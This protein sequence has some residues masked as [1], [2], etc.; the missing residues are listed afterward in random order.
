MQPFFG[1]N[2]QSREDILEEAFFLMR[3]LQISYESIRNMPVIYRSWFVRRIIKERKQSVPL[4]QYGLDDDTPISR[5][6]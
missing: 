1:L 3:N 2:D 6:Q 4:D 5:S